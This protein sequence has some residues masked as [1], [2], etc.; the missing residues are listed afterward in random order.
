MHSDPSQ[1]A[2]T[3]HSGSESFCFS[4]EVIEADRSACA[5]W[6]SPNLPTRLENIA[7][8]IAILRS[9]LDR[10]IS[11]PSKPQLIREILEQS[12]N[13]DQE[14]MGWRISVPREWE[15]FS[16][17]NSD[18]GKIQLDEAGSA[19]AKAWHGYTASYPDLV[20]AKSLNYFR[21]HSIAIQSIQIRCASW[22]VRHGSAERPTPEVQLREDVATA[23]YSSTLVKAQNA[24][25]TLVDG[26]CASVPFHLDKFA[27][28]VG[29]NESI[30]RER[31]GKPFEQ[32][33]RAGGI[34]T[35]GTAP[36][37]TASELTG[38]WGPAV[39][40][41]L[42]QPLVISFT[43]PGVP[44]GQKT[45]ILDKLLVVARHIGMDEEMV[46]MRLNNLA[47]G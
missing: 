10:V 9:K 32:I 31:S 36:N 47:R 2:P 30:D 29:Q 19:H 21:M 27:V 35:A 34:A 24:I 16:S 12:R 14:L 5:T 11:C 38:S 20:S 41:M 1:T 15:T 17:D 45:W 25:R 28:K 33:E 46:V 40:F 42:L 23:Q 22:I 3:A 4:D 13:L 26:I 8:A 44:A 39:A 18:Q 37:Q 7:F 6:P 43:A